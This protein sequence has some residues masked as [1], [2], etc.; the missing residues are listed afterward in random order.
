MCGSVGIRARALVCR[1]GPDALCGLASIAVFLAFWEAASSPSALQ[2]TEVIPPPSAVLQRWHELLWS[3]DYWRSWMVTS[4]RVLLGFGTAVVLGV[5][6]GLLMSVNRTIYGLVF[7]TFEV[8]RPIP[9]LAWVPISIVFWPTQEL[10]IM[11]VIFLGAFT[12]MVIN[13]LG[14]ARA[15]DLRYS[16]AARSMGSSRWDIFRRITFPGTVPSI[17]VGAEVGMGITWAIVVAGEMIAGG[18]AS[19]S[20]GAG[21][22]GYFIWT[23]YVGSSFPDIIVGMFS[24]GVGGFVSSAA[25]RATGG[26]A[27]PYLRQR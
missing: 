16:Q 20:G 21:G 6:V 8:L 17:L 11:F 14:G 10:S 9:P 12:T 2:L 23:S 18:G 26:I 19:L 5:I 3:A 4:S 7:P 24:V 25:V 22:L 27:T 1:I 13:V 15:L